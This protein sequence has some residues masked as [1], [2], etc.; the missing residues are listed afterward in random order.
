MFCYVFPRQFLWF[1]VVS[2]FVFCCVV[3]LSG[4]GDV[5]LSLYLLPCCHESKKGQDVNA[6]NTF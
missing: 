1:S 4:D 5:A 2:M 3:V 6:L